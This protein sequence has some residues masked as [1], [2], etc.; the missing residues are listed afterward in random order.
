MDKT[1][2]RP[3]TLAIGEAGEQT[4][5]EDIITITRDFGELSPDACVFYKKKTKFI[6]V[7]KRGSDSQHLFRDSYDKGSQ[8]DKPAPTYETKDNGSQVN[9][10]ASTHSNKETGS[11]ADTHACTHV[12]TNTHE[13]HKHE[14]DCMTQ[15]KMYDVL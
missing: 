8:V 11:R 13:D 7:I 2:G 3:D 10:L 15:G 1:P 12:S 9:T 4:A 5:E 6:P 14:T